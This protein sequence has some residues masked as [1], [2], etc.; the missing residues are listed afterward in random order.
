MQQLGG[1]KVQRK[2]K[3]KIKIKIKEIW[4]NWRCIE[5]W[6]EEKRKEKKDLPALL[7]SSSWPLLLFFSFSFDLSWPSNSTH[8][9]YTKVHRMWVSECVRLGKYGVYSRNKS[10]SKLKRES[11]RSSKFICSVSIRFVLFWHFWFNV[12]VHHTPYSVGFVEIEC[13]SF[14][15]GTQDGELQLNCLSSYWILVTVFC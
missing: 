5:L 14:V 2:R 3:E 8:W 4:K 13:N 10:K 6:M 7:S 9:A 11:V 12:I 15:F 1:K